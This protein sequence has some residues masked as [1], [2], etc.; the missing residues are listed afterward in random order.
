LSEFQVSISEIEQSASKLSGELNSAMKVAKANIEKFHKAQIPNKVAVE[1]MPGVNCWQVAVP[2]ELANC[3]EVVLCTPPNKDGRIHPAMLYAA[4]LVGISKIYKVGGA[5]AI[6][7]MAYGTESVPKVNKIFGPGNQYVTCAKQLVSQGKTAIDMPAGPS[8]VLIYADGNAPIQFVAADLLSQAEHGVDSHVVLI[9]D[10]EANVFAVLN[11][12]E[13]Q[14][15]NLPRQNIA[16]KVMEKSPLIIVKDKTEVIDLI[17]LYAPEHL[18]LCTSMAQKM[19]RQVKN[20]GSIFLGYYTPESAGDYASGT[21]HT[22]PTNGFA[23]N[24]SGVNMDA[25]YKKITYQEI[26]KKGIQELGATV[27]VLAAAEELMAHKHA[28]SVRL[29]AVANANQTIK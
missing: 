29:E 14:L 25:F 5:Q 1:T 26:S 7:A 24:Y 20:A 2:I 28:V 10:T 27:E 19:A 8:E 15:K 13:Q 17:N 16:R 23:K 12:V 22:L 9:L 11:E 21:N 6:A 4:K 3:K 18:I